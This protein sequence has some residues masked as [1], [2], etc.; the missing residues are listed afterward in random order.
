MSFFS[1]IKKWFELQKTVQHVVVDQKSILDE[2]VSESFQETVVEEVELSEEEQQFVQIK[3]FIESDDVSNHE[4]AAMFMAGL[5]TIWD[6]EMYEMVSKSADKMTFWASQENNNEFVTYFTK[7]VITPRFFSQY[8][9]IAAFAKI[10]PSFVA[11]E[12]LQWK[13][14]HY[15]NQHPILVSASKLPNLKR[16]YAEDCKMNFLP[17]SLIEAPVL[18]ELYL[19]NNKL[20]EM[21]AALDQ[22][23]HLRILDLS[24]NQL[25]KCPRSVCRLKKLETLRLQ[26]NPIKDI[27][28]RMFG[29]LYKLTDLQLPAVLAKFNLDTLQDWLPDVDFDKSYWKFD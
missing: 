28:P 24:D 2:G 29:Q 12:E 10:L 4:L 7:L 8:S 14:K 22:L 9:E 11:L 15:W 13:A 18:E 17:E 3:Q 21:P 20:T 27:E 23:I 19:S 26:D 5:G 6:E 16:L 1:K 25:T